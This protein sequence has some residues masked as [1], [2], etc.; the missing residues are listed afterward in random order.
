MLKAN[1][2]LG[3]IFKYI[4]TCIHNWPLKFFSQD[5]DSASQISYVVCVNFIRKWLNF[6]EI[7]EYFSYDYNS[8][9]YTTSV[10]CLYQT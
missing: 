8:V 4:H 5:Y 3:K 7:F 9:A 10:V 2:K 6:L 1:Q